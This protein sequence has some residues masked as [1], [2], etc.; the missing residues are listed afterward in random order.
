MNSEA[1]L[2]REFSVGISVGTTMLRCLIASSNRKKPEHPTSPCSTAFIKHRLPML[3]S[4]RGCRTIGAA[5]RAASVR[6]HS[7]LRSAA[8]KSSCPCANLPPHAVPALTALLPTASC[9][10]LLSTAAATVVGCAAAGVAN[11]VEGVGVATSGLAGILAAGG[12]SVLIFVGVA[13]GAG[14]S[15]TFFLASAAQLIALGTGG[16]L[17]AASLAGASV[18]ATACL[19]IACLAAAS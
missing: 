18:S 17:G 6:G 3:V 8:A 16:A 11:G 4:P 12:V 1:R 9:A 13:G 7:S 5:A 2:T 15:G 19:V 14:G 10:S